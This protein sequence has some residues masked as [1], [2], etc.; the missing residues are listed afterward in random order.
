MFSR[1]KAL[2][3]VTWFASTARNALVVLAGALLAWALGQEVF[4]L[5]GDI[6][7]GLPNLQ[8]PSLQASYP[9]PGTGDQKTD[10][11][12]QMLSNLGSLVILLPLVTVMQHV[13]IAKAFSNFLQSISNENGVSFLCLY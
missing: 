12:F 2:S 6:K 11:V 4:R 13:A 10:G 9:D 5:T 3:R 1:S 8:L 7:V